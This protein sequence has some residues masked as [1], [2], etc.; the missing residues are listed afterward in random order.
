MSGKRELFQPAQ[1]WSWLLGWGG[2]NNKTIIKKTQEWMKLETFVVQCVL[3]KLD[4]NKG[5]VE[6][7]K[8][9]V[10]RETKEKSSDGAWYTSSGLR[11]QLRNRT[12]ER[13]QLKNGPV[14]YTWKVKLIL[15]SI[16]FRLMGPS[17]DPGGS[18]VPKISW[19]RWALREAQL[20]GGNI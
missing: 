15:P 6:G 17:R 13:P 16:I 1:S 19:W 4:S 5:Q 9:T 14:C 3:M 12:Q 18:L 8:P 11:G 7:H 2:S 10:Q 20:Q